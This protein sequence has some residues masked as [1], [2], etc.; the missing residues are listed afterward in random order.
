MIDRPFQ[1]RFAIYTCSWLI[2]LGFVYP[3]IVRNLF[4]FF[5]RY[6]QHDPNGP[7]A[8]FL[9]QTQAETMGLLL[10]FQVIFLMI[11]FLISIFMSH[12]VAGPLYKLKQF[13]TR[14]KNGDLSEDLYFRKADY[15][16]DIAASYN[17][18]IHEVRGN[19]KKNHETLDKIAAKIE[20]ATPKDLQEISNILNETRKQNQKMKL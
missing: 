16:Q 18:M 14:A 19:L 12:R 9:K 3:L 10:G 6:A 11:T 17:E 20:G 4:E 13:F 8:E 7:P 2:A 15:F 1:L 5:I